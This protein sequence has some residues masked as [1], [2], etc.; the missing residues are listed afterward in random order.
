MTNTTDW[1][2]EKETLFQTA[3]RLMALALRINTETSVAVFV[4]FSGHVDQ[5]EVEICKS[6]Q[7]Y[8][9]DIAKMVIRL[10]DTAL[11]NADRIQTA[12]DLLNEILDVDTTD[13]RALRTICE[14]HPA[15]HMSF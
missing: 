13:T 7:A 8:F 1:Q 10:D 11:Q 12:I 14:Q 4:N 5:L 2:S 3:G 15:T 6:K 9:T